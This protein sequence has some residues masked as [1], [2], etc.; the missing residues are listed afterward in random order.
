[1]TEAIVQRKRKTWG[2]QSAVPFLGKITV[3]L[4]N[5]SNSHTAVD[6]GSTLAD[7]F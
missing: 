1:M 5:D 6:C 4:R 2:A 3:K 7:I